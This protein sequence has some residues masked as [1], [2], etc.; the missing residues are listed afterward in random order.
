LAETGTI[1]FDRAS[2]SL[3]VWRIPTNRS[4]RPDAVRVTDSPL[5]DGCP[6]VSRNGGLL[7]FTRRTDD[8]RQI[9]AKDLTSGQESVWVETSADKFWPTPDGKGERIAFESRNRDKSSI[10][11][12]VSGHGI[13]TLCTGCSHPASWFR[14][15]AILYT[16]A[17]GSIAAIDIASNRTQMVVAAPP[18]FF[19]SDPDWSPDQDYLL[20][21]SR[22]ES[23]KQVFAV[24]MS[25]STASAEGRWIP[26]TPEA[27]AADHPRWAVG[28]SAALY[29]SKRDGNYCVW[30]RHFN[31]NAAEAAGQTTEILP[32]HTQ[33]FSPNRTG[34][35]V[36][37]VSV[38]AD[39][40][41]INV[42]D[43]IS[44]IWT[45]TLKPG[46]PTFF[47]SVALQSH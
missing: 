1:A 31:P 30:S 34:P 25:Q 45:G 17:S 32:F 39:S 7:F 8:F 15:R 22:T 16:T 9:M 46:L 20:F 3:H 23:T 44:S 37:G 24:H 12:F 42:G 6:S 14:D 47:R 18:G 43:V 38:S 21:T 11:L 13:R 2:G 27:D 40:V 29:L 4:G 28:G 33:R 36:L 19:L 26:I 35:T 5:A 10:D 41:F